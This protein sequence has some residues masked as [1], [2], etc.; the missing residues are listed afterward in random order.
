MGIRFWTAF[1][2]AL[3]MMV[4]G[5]A[6]SVEGAEVARAPVWPS[7]RYYAVLKSAEVPPIQG[8][9][10]LTAA[11]WAKAPPMG[12]FW[13]RGLR[14]SQG[15][16]T[17]VR[18]IDS[19]GTLYLA[20]RCYEDQPAGIKVDANPAELWKDDSLE[21]MLAEGP[22]GDW[23]LLHVLVSASGRYSLVRYVK[24]FS[25]WG[26]RLEERVDPSTVTVKTAVDK[27]G[28][29]AFLVLSMGELGVPRPEFHVNI[30]RNRP[31]DN[32]SFSWVDLWG[33][34]A[35]SIYRM[36]TV[37][38]VET[39]PKPSPELELPAELGV[40][41]N[42]LK[43]DNWRTDCR[44]S[45]NGK[46]IPVDGQGK[47]EVLIERHG[48]VS[49]SVQP[50][51]GRELAGFEADV[52]RPLIV[53]AKNPFGGNVAGP[54]PVTLTLNLAADSR[55][56]VELVGLQ[57]RKPVG[58]MK[59]TL[60]SG[61]H[62][63]ELPLAGAGA[64][65]VQI[66]ATARLAGATPVTVSARHWCVL[67]Q[68][69]DAFDRYREGIERLPTASLLRAGV[70]DA[71]N[72]W[73]LTQVGTGVI[74]RRTAYDWTQA[75]TYT[76]AQVYAHPWPEN[77]F[78][79]DQR[80]LDAAALGLETALDPEL[81]QR[82]CNEPD[83]RAL[84]GFLLAYDLLKNDVPREQAE[85][86][87]RILT[88]AVQADIEIWLRPAGFRLTRYIADVGTGTN[89]WSLHMA[90]VYTAGKVFGRKDWMEL[91]A[92]EM[93]A[94]A[95]HEQDG[96]FPERR[97][98][99]T[100]SYSS[101]TQAGLAEYYF[102]S[103]DETVR[104]S[105]LRC[106]EFWR[107][108]TLWDGGQMTF[109]NGRVNSGGGR[110]LTLLPFAV[111]AEGRAMAHAWALNVI[112]SGN[113]PSQTGAETWFRL[114]EAAAQLENGPEV[115][116]PNESEFV[117]M[118][119]RVLV[120]R[121]GRFQYGLSAMCLPPIT[122]LFQIDPQNAVEVMHE[123]GGRVLLGN[124]SQAQPE[125]GSFFRKVGERAVW[126][127]TDG[128]IERTAGG[129]VAI[130]T[131]DRFKTRLWVQVLSDNEAEVKVELL[132]AEGNE[133][134]VYNFFPGVGRN[135][136]GLTV[137]QDGRTLRFGRVT[138]EAS[139]P[140]QVQRDFR[141]YDPYSGNYRVN[142]KPVRAFTELDRNRPFVLRIKV[143]QEGG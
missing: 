59:T 96:Q 60:A 75:M 69:K 114:G 72:Y 103:G 120:V 137:S 132:E 49:V 108:T 135:D 67:G 128:S 104:D 134:V 143:S 65:E 24:P 94:L 141:M 111:N 129:H 123:G 36:G 86:W 85:R 11:A 106:V 39:L 98:V 122:G 118:D 117:Y 70:A 44:L 92:Q 138:L 35:A 9:E 140:V 89:H 20:V 7:G 55:A 77:P 139:A 45:V 80:F 14:E 105:L 41:L 101:L 95:R 81:H 126:L 112:H 3:G 2:A 62:A 83:N 42:V 5:W 19:G 47:A 73:R 97:G 28:W 6:L 48:P 30:V 102:Q 13:S 10:A 29:S 121:R 116:P 110:N 16:R 100:P 130:L 87:K 78:V 46:P 66:V 1:A 26:P 22:G 131:F 57:N 40:G 113:R 51:A 107:R 17:E 52:R 109:H 142:S 88:D 133:P 15:R 37:T 33:G 31:A 91:G 38:M 64:G 82:W 99:P 4:G 50:S 12:G 23:P 115:A 32:S 136:P 127:P 71:A 58:Q 8:P 79:K 56:E 21:L 68:D 74:G 119:G 34:R 61:A 90:N 76:L 18:M 25:L 43:L 124:N 53:E 54:L 93:R 63:L 84:Q 27:E 125:A